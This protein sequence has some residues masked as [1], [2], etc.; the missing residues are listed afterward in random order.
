MS[1]VF[2][3]LPVRILTSS[4]T[5]IFASCASTL[6]AEH[7]LCSHCDCAESV[8]THFC[9]QKEDNSSSSHVP[10]FCN[11]GRFTMRLSLWTTVI[12]CDAWYTSMCLPPRCS[13]SCYALSESQLVLD[14]VVTFICRDKFS[15]LRFEATK[16]SALRPRS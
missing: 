6:C 12:A 7:T 4:S 15:W 14:V 9:P 1:I 13:A 2:A 8:Q 3:C 16:L 11:S 10:S 5:H